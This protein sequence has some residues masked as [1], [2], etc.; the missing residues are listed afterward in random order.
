METS[1]FFTVTSEVGGG[2]AISSAD[3]HS[4]V[5]HTL[6]AGGEGGGVEKKPKVKRSLNR[7]FWDFPFGGIEYD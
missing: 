2:G 7:I 6:T 3:C 1:P 5:E 4:A